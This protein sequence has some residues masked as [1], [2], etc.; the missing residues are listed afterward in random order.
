MLPSHSL[1]QVCKNQGAVTKWFPFH[2]S[3]SK[4]RKMH[5]DTTRDFSGIAG[6]QTKI[7]CLKKIILMSAIIDRNMTGASMVLVLFCIIPLGTAWI[8]YERDLTAADAHILYSQKILPRG[9]VFSKD[10]NCRGLFFQIPSSI[11]GIFLQLPIW[12]LLFLSL[13]CL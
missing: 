11:R 3:W 5:L 6:K 4:G 12:P 2:K 10:L 9:E 13:L 8:G 1:R 7:S